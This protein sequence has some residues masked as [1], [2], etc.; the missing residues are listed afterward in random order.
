MRRIDGVVFLALVLL[1]ACDGGETDFD[2]GRDAGSFDAGGGGE[3]AG[4][5][6]G[7]HDA[8][9]DAGPWPTCDAQPAGSTETTIPAIWADESVLPLRAWVPGVYVSAISRGGC[10]AGMVCQIYVQQEP[11]YA[12]LAEATHQSIRVGISSAAASY[13]EGIAVGDEIDLFGQALRETTTDG[14][15]ELIFLITETMPGCAAVVTSGTALTPVT[16]MLDDLT[17]DGYEHDIGPV[18][19]RVDLVSGRAQDADEIFALWETDQPINGDITTVTSL[20][21][22]YTAGGAFT[23]LTAGEIVDFEYVVGV[24]GVF[25]P[26]ATPLI[27]YESIYVRSAADYPIAN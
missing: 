26:P 25:A 1:G 6:A 13:F 17:V 10:T 21:P 7:R 4:M 5:D 24:F 8:G 18:L 11:S 23:G 22:F 12:S 19:V 9:I 15:D 20:S 16:V 2:A 27:K 14:R 3:D